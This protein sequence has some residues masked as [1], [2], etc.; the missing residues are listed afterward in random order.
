VA[1]TILTTTYSSVPATAVGSI[2]TWT[3][4]VSDSSLSTF[5]YSKT[6][7]IQYVYP[8]YYGFTSSEITPGSTSNLSSIVSSFNKLIL[9]YPGSGGSFSIPYNGSGY[10]Y[11]IHA[12]DT[13]WESTGSP[14]QSG[15][16]QIQDPNGF[17]I[18]DSTLPA[19]TAFTYSTYAPSGGNNLPTPVPS[20][21]VYRTIGTCS[22]SGSGEFEFIF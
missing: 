5:S 19:L 22:Y 9:P 12:R 8:I 15:L 7:T 16:Q 18:H 3:L 20:Y 14:M 17:I 21:K 13:V 1:H 2:K 11:F 4:N 10:I 6:A